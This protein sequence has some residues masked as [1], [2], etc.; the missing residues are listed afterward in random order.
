MKT[1]VLFDIDGTLITCGKTPRKS[2]TRAME[3]IFGTRGGVDAYPFSGKTDTQIV[4]DVMTAANFSPR[5]VQERMI[6]ALRRYAELLDADLKPDDI[7]VL[8]GVVALLDA[9]SARPDTVTGL[10][11]GNIIEGARIKLSRAG[12]DHYFFNGAP[13]IGAF[14]SDSMHRP[15]LAS[16]AVRRAGEIT[17]QTFNG[18]SVV[19]VGDS[20]YDILCGKHLNVKSVAVTTGWHSVQELEEH[21]PDH[22]LSSFGDTDAALYCLFN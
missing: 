2:I 8:D 12:L 16:L 13:V 18:K 3:E 4:W 9:L 21:V 19:I 14:G 1:L 7:Q 11:T 22:L 5:D 20:P 6:P 17:G 10:L 15:E